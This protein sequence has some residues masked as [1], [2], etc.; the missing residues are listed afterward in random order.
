[1]SETAAAIRELI[2]YMKQYEIRQTLGNDRASIQFSDGTGNVKRRYQAAKE[3]GQDRDFVDALES[4]PCPHPFVIEAM[5]GK[6]Q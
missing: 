1:M 4:S 5:K 2:T 6:K 3:S